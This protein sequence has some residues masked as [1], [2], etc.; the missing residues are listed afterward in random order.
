MNEA[1]IQTIYA[2]EGKGKRKKAVLYTTL[3]L[4]THN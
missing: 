1:G 2:L 3:T 4:Y